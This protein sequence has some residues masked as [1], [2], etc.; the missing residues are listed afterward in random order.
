VLPTII[1]IMVNT[2]SYNEKTHAYNQGDFQILKNNR[3]WMNVLKIN[4]E[5]AL[6]WEDVL[7]MGAERVWLRHD[8]HS[9]F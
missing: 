7:K 3:L 1:A 6:S 8:L 9:H 4:G 5:L 2:P